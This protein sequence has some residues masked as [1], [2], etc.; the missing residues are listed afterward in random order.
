MCNLA[1]ILGCNFLCFSINCDLTKLG[2]SKVVVVLTTTVVVAVANYI[3][4]VP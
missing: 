4:S 2:S 3:F 1:K